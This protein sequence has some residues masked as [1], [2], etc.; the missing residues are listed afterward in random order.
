MKPD[1]QIKLQLVAEVK[2]YKSAPGYMLPIYYKGS[3]IRIN[4][5]SQAEIDIEALEY[6]PKIQF[7]K[8]LELKHII[9]TGD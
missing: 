9:E 6:E 3:I 5:E 4:E 8:A 2:K 7:K 1:K